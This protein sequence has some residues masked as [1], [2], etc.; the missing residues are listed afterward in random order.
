V[1][2]FSG[3]RVSRGQCNV[4]SS[5]SSYCSPHALF[6]H[7]SSAIRNVPGGKVRILGG[8]SIG[9]SKQESVYVH[10]SCSG[11]FPRQ[12]FHV[13][14]RIKERRDALRRATRHVL[15]QAAKCID[16][17]GGIFENVL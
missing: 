6:V 9:H 16:V 12:L 10:V 4:F 5:I 7:L 13:I 1:P 2:T 15:I 17:D 11:R 3:W 8:H 14:A